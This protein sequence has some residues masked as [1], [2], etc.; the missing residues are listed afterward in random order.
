[1]LPRRSGTSRAGIDDKILK[2]A[3]DI[4]A[5]LGGLALGLPFYAPIALAIKLGSR[6]GVFYTQERI[7]L[8]GR[9]FRILKFRTMVQDADGEGAITYKNDA[10]I[11]RVGH[12]LRRFKL[13]EWPTL[14]NVLKGDMS[15]VGPRPEIPLYVDQYTPE[16]RRTLSVRPGITDPGTLRFNYEA[17]IMSDRDRSGAVYLEKV[18][19][20]KLRL[21]LEYLDKRS[22][23]QDLSIIFATMLLIVRQRRG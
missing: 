12:W 14:L 20:E 22:F 9:P 11:T 13:D 17:G 16:Q 23:F 8:H 7:G 4:V 15:V 18:L 2:R 3:F 19:P 6:G 21:N 1:M 10:R 5:A